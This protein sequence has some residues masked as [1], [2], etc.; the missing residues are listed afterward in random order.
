MKKGRILSWVFDKDRRIILCFT[1]KACDIMA[2]DKS[3]LVE[4][5]PHCVRT[6]KNGAVTVYHLSLHY[7]P[8]FLDE[9]VSFGG[10]ELTSAGTSRLFSDITHN[11]RLC[12]FGVKVVIPTSGT[13]TK[14]WNVH[15]IKAGISRLSSGTT[16]IRNQPHRKDPSHK[17]LRTVGRKLY[18]GCL[19][20]SRTHTKK[21]VCPPY[22]ESMD[23]NAKR[24]VNT[25]KKAIAKLRKKI[26]H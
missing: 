18:P 17:R 15:Q 13:F 23:W 12:F 25:Y 14:N 26:S 21:Q 8:D 5:P 11:E 1:K 9:T 2:L 24:T 10:E 20:D 6:G 4:M 3:V 16:W 7:L 19:D 22:S